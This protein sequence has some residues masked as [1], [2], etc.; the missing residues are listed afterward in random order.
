LL[1]LPNDSDNLDELSVELLKTI[2]YFKLNEGSPA[3]G[4]GIM[5]SNPGNTDFWG[6]PLLPNKP[7]NVGA[8]QGK[9]N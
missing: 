1:I 7:V 4:T 5:I 9:G 8:Y 2:D 6:N 3:I